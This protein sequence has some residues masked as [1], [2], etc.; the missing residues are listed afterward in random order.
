MQAQEPRRQFCRIQVF[1]R[2]LRNQGCSSTKDWIGAVASRYFPHRTLFLASEQI[3][4]D[5][6]CPRGP[7]WIWLTGPSG[8]H[9]N[10][11]P[12]VKYQFHQGFWPDRRSGNPYHHSFAPLL[13]YSRYSNYWKV[14]FLKLGFLCYVC[15]PFNSSVTDIE[16]A[17]IWTAFYFLSLGKGSLPKIIKILKPLWRLDFKLLLE[18]FA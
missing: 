18:E 10:K 3:F 1:H 15:F 14:D 13:I 11:P 7:T 12:W 6:K 16:I 4:K 5:L 17:E 2:K 8:L 9:R